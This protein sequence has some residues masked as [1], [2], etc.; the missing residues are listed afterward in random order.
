MFKLYGLSS[1]TNPDAFVEEEKVIEKESLPE[2]VVYSLWKRVECSDGKKKMK[3]VK[4]EVEREK[5]WNAWEIELTEFRD[6]VFR[7]QRQ[8]R[9]SRELKEHL[10]DNEVYVHMEFAEN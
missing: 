1:T 7:V 4:E 8:F 5:F 3:I 6:H 10:P 9:M 2:K